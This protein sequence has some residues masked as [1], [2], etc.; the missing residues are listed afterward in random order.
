[1]FVDWFTVIAQIINFIIL[2][3]LLKRFLYEPILQAVDE[4]EKKI[5]SRLADAELKISEAQIEKD[6]FHRKNEDIELRR[7]ELLKKAESE[8]DAEK[9]RLLNEIRAEAEALRVK[10]N[11]ELK[12]E[13]DELK[14]EIVRRINEEV[15]A[16]AKKALADLAGR[17]LNEYIFIEFVRRFRDMGDE[18][19]NSIIESC[20]KNSPQKAFINSAFEL[21]PKCRAEIQ[22]AADEL[23]GA[24][25]VEL[26]FK[27]IPDLVCGVEFTAGGYKL[28]WNI[29]DYTVRLE[30]DV[31]L[32]LENNLNSKQGMD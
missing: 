16:V 21:D 25:K 14:N 4:R 29:S 26:Q 9:Q 2:I 11:E 12:K 18:C 23:F 10:L 31:G 7:Q 5:S 3:W 28:A 1:M 27:L 6:E 15:F 22:N 13:K 17:G 19:K 24:D 32:F 8:S 30:K 20:G